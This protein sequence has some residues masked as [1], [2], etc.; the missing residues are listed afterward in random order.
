VGKQLRLVR[1]GPRRGHRGTV[2]TRLLS[3]VAILVL[4]LTALTT[5]IVSARSSGF[6]QVAAPTTFK[7]TVTNAD[8]LAAAQRAAA[9][10]AA[11]NGQGGVTPAVAP[12]S[13]PDYF[14]TT[15]NYANSP[16]PTSGA[17][18][19]VT[20][21]GGSGAAAS[22][23]VVNGTVVSVAITNAGSGYTSPPTVSFSGG[24]GAGATVKPRATA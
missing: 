14:G 10:R 8:R 6:C 13:T 20:G 4:S 11:C 16:L 1:G 15:P 21:G 22:A 7:G 12:L 23:T 3:T 24:S 5:P 9:G 17:S 2:G 18:V 19:S